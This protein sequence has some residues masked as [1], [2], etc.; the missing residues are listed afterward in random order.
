MRKLGIF[1]LI[2]TVGLIFVSC[3]IPI[4]W[5]N[6]ENEDIIIKTFLNGNLQQ[7]EF[8]AYQDGKDGR[9]EK[10]DSTTGIYTF[11][12]EADD[13]NYSIYAVNEIQNNEPMYEIK[14]MNFNTSELS[15]IPINF[16]TYA[17]TSPEAT[18]MLNFNNDFLEKWTGAYWGGKCHGFYDFDNPAYL[19]NNEVYGVMPGTNDLVI[20]LGDLINRGNYWS[21]DFINKIFIERGFTI[22]EGEQELDL[23]LNEFVD[24]ETFVATSTIA[25]AYIESNLLVGGTT[26]VFTWE[27][28]EDHFIKLPASLKSDKDLYIL[29][30]VNNDYSNNISRLFKIYKSNPNDY[31]IINVFPADNWEKPT[32]ANNTFYW[33]PPY[34]PNITG[35]RMRFYE[36]SL[37]NDDYTIN[38]TFLFSNGWLGE[39]DSYEYELPK[40]NNLAGWNDLWYPQEPIDSYQFFLTQ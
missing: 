33:T 4:D 34:D 39:A 7:I 5:F 22:S 19:T 40:L 28:P 2:L 17:S 21:R 13:G 11:K 36:A 32:F 18:L 25:D 9:W 31:E 27:L 14:I 6:D 23:L 16:Y 15:E 37:N 35:H 1:L 38:W 10:L 12:P 24:I 3:T 20:L 26:N 29:S 8:L 30:L